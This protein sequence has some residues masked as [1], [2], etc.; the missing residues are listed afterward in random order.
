M[1]ILSL[2]PSPR[3]TRTDPLFPYTTLFRSAFDLCSSFVE[4]AQ[5]LVD[6][7]VAEKRIQPFENCQ[8]NRN[9][10]R[11]EIN[12][13]FR[14]GFDVDDDAVDLMVRR[15]VLYRPGDVAERL[16]VQDTAVDHPGL[17]TRKR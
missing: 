3:S 9:L 11:R 7:L 10:F 4:P 1:F 5:V 6:R 17:P 2:R 16:V 12:L 15:L 13:R 8:G 14:V